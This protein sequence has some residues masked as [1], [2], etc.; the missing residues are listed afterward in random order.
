LLDTAVWNDPIASAD[1]TGGYITVRNLE[2]LVD[3]LHGEQYL[4]DGNQREIVVTDF[5]VR[6]E[7]ANAED[8][9]GTAIAFGYYKA[10]SL[11]TVRGIIY[12]SCADTGDSAG[13]RDENGEK[14][15]YKVF[16]ALNTNRAEAETEFALRLIG[17]NRWA[18][19][20]GS[21]KVPA[22]AYAKEH[23][24]IRYSSQIDG[25]KRRNVF[26][27][28]TGASN[29]FYPSEGAVS[30]E[31][32]ELSEGF[33]LYCVL[34][35]TGYGGVSAPVE[36]G[37]LKKAKLL[38]V[39]MRVDGTE[40]GSANVRVVLVGTVNGQCYS[41]Y[42][43]GRIVYGTDSVVEVDVSSIGS[44]RGEIDRIKILTDANGVKQTLSIGSVDVLYKPTSV[45]LIVLIVVLSLGALFGLF[46]LFL[47]LRMLYYRQMKK[48]RARKRLASAPRKAGAKPAEKPKPK[49]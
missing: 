5:A 27:F 37:A 8:V 15:S 33:E 34:D 36:K 16:G 23:L 32:K 47:Y 31:L 40:Q 10:L 21:F 3:F 1:L 46:V 22:P 11:E 26:D 28:S 24:Q 41:W 2:M 49:K 39:G 9:Q 6:T 38:T 20:V 12:A 29:G 17:V 19:V 13:L 25:L 18:S 43:D 48:I 35:G 42:A 45:W 14:R 44:F 30:S 7:G 4:F